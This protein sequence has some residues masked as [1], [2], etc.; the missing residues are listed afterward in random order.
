MWH[1]G[2]SS[3]VQPPWY[4]PGGV[5]M[6][7]FIPPPRLLL[8]ASDGRSHLKHVVRPTTPM[9][10]PSLRLKML[11]STADGEQIPDTPLKSAYLTHKWNPALTLQLT[12]S[13]MLLL[14]GMTGFLSCAATVIGALPLQFSGGRAVHHTMVCTMF[15]VISFFS[16]RFV[17][18]KRPRSRVR[19]FYHMLD[20]P[21]WAPH[22]V[23]FGLVWLVVKLLW[24]AAMTMVYE[25]VG[26]KL[27]SPPIELHLLH[28][29]LGDVWNV[30]YSRE[31]QLGAGLPIIVA[32]VCSFFASAKAA[33]RVNPLAGL[34]YLPSCAWGLVATALNY[35]LWRRNGKHPLYLVC[36][37]ANV[38]GTNASIATRGG[39]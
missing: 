26:G 23:A 37:S 4:G 32:L 13:F 14:A 10:K 9:W 1:H 16:Y 34:L 22:P 29:A 21:S 11:S 3:P 28:L 36:Q 30:I 6:A 24:M 17:P 2:L 12:T 5:G 33:Y 39:G 19:N 7:S 31:N 25:G 20:K 38:V 8:E 27:F 15:G 18:F 35:E